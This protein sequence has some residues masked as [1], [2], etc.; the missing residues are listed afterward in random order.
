MA[1]GR[2]AQQ[3]LIIIVIKLEQDDAAVPRKKIEDDGQPGAGLMGIG[4]A[5]SGPGGAPGF[6]AFV[7]GR[8]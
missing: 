3:A 8:R 6:G 1:S 4:A 5:D 2:L 7:R